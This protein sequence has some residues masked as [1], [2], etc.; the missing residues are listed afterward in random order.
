MTQIDPVT[1]IDQNLKELARLV[2]IR[3]Q[4]QAQITK[5]TARI[6]AFITLLDNEEE[7][8]ICRL[9]LTAASK[10]VGL[11]DTVKH[12]L[13]KEKKQLTPSAL[14]DRL[15]ESGFPVSGY[16]NELAVICTTL[17]R[18]EGQKL[19]GRTPDGAYEWIGP[20]NELS[21]F[22][23]TMTMRERLGKLRKK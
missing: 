5:T 22:P 1:I 23:S 12:I 10:P 17:T 18:L 13:R 16:A 2:E 4:T 9:S 6:E 20:Y 3:E 19:V 7:Q 11:T 14:R 15:T 8:R 21:P